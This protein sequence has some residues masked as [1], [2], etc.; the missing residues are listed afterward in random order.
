MKIKPSDMINEYFVSWD[1]D[2][3]SNYKKLILKNK[4]IH[5]EKNM[6]TDIL[7]DARICI[8]TYTC[9]HILTHT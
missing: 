8:I 2:A 6:Y 7:I 3:G 9:M 5:R 4:H 1:E